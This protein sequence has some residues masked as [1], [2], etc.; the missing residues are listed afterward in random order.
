M[1]ST[2]LLKQTLSEKVAQPSAEVVTNQVHG[3]VTEKSSTVVPGPSLSVVLTFSVPLCEAQR[4]IERIQALIASLG[5]QDGTQH[6]I[7]PSLVPLIE[8][9]QPIT[10]VEAIRATCPAVDTI[11]VPLSI[12]QV[13]GKSLSTASITD[14]QQQLLQRL[15]IRQHL[16]VDTLKQILIE[17]YGVETGS[18][19]SRK[20]ASELIGAWIVR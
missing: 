1:M 8:S 17:K 10:T 20:Q 9:C 18:Q 16:S 3:A 2:A 12:Q 11:P 14:K 6:Q 7:R 4:Q 13:P 5:L 19:L 15:A